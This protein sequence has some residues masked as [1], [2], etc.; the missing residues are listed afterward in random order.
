MDLY[1]G[2][3]PPS[4]SDGLEGGERYTGKGGVL[5]DVLKEGAGQN[6]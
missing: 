3:L 1:H 4:S 2:T 6:R 5:P